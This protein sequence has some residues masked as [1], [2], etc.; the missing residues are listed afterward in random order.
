[1]LESILDDFSAHGS[2]PV[3]VAVVRLLGAALMAACIG[4]ERELK[5]HP[6]GLRTHMLVAL[7]SA[8]FAV[9]AVEIVSSPVFAVDQARIDP[10]RIIQ[11]VTSGVALLAAGVVVFFRGRIQGVTT[12]AGI[13]LASSIGLA[14]GFGFWPIAFA[15]T[16]I[17]IIV[18]ILLRRFEKAMSLK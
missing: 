16:I 8:M 7:A 17:G 12:G 10:L 6:A 14:T 18:L 15:A 9:L 13:W 11:A 3:A 2:L 4:F 1:M 5:D